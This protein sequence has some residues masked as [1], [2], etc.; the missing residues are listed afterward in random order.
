MKEKKQFICV[1]IEIG[2]EGPVSREELMSII[3][4]ELDREF[5]TGADMKNTR[6]T[7]TTNDKGGHGPGPKK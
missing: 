4:A 5:P 6:I 7:I 3:K 2:Q 1:D